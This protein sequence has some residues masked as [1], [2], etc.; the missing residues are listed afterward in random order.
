[1]FSDRSCIFIPLTALLTVLVITPATELMTDT[2]SV[3]ATTTHITKAITG[4]NAAE[5]YEATAVAT[6]VIIT[7][8]LFINPVFDVIDVSL[9]FCCVLLSFS[10]CPVAVLI[11]SAYF[12]TAC[13]A[14][15]TTFDVPA[16]DA[17][18]AVSAAAPSDTFVTEAS[19]PGLLVFL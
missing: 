6:V 13:S 14:A 15:F 18:A 2:R 9:A 7:A 10:F 12:F 3:A 8:T 11:I 16:V 19:A 5:R 1:M 17:V 4:I